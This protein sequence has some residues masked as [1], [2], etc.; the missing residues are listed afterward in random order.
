M[1]SQSPVY[2]YI[3]YLKASTASDCSQEPLIKAQTFTN[4][5]SSAPWPLFSNKNSAEDVES[6]LF[7][8][9]TAVETLSQRTAAESLSQHS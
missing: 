5:D 8:Y 3:N 7:K 1:K 4:N 2:D 6:L 9:S